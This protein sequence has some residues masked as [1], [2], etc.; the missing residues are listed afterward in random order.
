MDIANRDEM[1]AYAKSC[2]DDNPILEKY[3]NVKSIV[4]ESIE[5]GFNQGV[6]HGKHKGQLELIENMRKVHGID[7]NVG[8]F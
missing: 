7:C 1:L 6:I 8:K 5:Y 2:I 3:P 4:Y